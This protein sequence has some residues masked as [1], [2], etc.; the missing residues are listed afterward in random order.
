MCAI[1][2]FLRFVPGW[3]TS[4]AVGRSAGVASLVVRAIPRGKSVITGIDP[5]FGEKMKEAHLHKHVPAESPALAPQL[6]MPS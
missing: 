3:G 5:Q 6:A 1:G 4:E 2:K